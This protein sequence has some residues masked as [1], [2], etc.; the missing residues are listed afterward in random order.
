MTARASKT[1]TAPV[2]T[3]DEASGPLEF[4]SDGEVEEEVRETL[5]SLDGE[6]FTIPKVIDQRIVYLGLNKVRTEGA[7]FAAMYLAELLLGERQYERFIELYE[8]KKLTPKQFDQVTAVISSR[9]FDHIN[10][11]D[12]DAA[13]K[14]A[15]PSPT[16]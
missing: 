4:T 6:V 2:P 14:A 5:F 9:F 7:L 3:P 13:G 1:R 10:S 15:E 16:S 11:L 8:L 12:N